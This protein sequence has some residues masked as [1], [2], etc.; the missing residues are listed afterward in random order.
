MLLKG[1]ARAGTASLPLPRSHLPLQ[2]TVWSVP[3]VKSAHPQ[4][5]HWMWL[6]SLALS[7]LLWGIHVKKLIQLTRQNFNTKYYVI[8]TLKLE[9][10]IK[11][12]GDMEK[13]LESRFVSSVHLLCMT[14]ASQSQKHNFF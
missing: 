5:R 11:E 14:T 12:T 9:T 3:W 8:L 4:L 2:A 6:P 10:N 13:W 1:V 7:S